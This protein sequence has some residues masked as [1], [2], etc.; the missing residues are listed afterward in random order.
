MED[1]T[2]FLGQQQIQ[3]HENRVD[4]MLKNAVSVDF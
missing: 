2:G 4:V 1:P 3:L